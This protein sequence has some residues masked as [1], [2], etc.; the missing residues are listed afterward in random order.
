MITVGG[1][2]YNACQD[3]LKFS[4]LEVSSWLPVLVG[5]VR[6]NRMGHLS[7]NCTNITPKLHSVQ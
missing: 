4:Q 6:L 3:I 7:H 5:A 1:V 2:A